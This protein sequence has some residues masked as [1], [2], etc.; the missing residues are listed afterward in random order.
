MMQKQ[1]SGHS[2]LYN[3]ANVHTGVLVQFIMRSF[4]HTNI[5]R[6]VGFS[7]KINEVIFSSY[8]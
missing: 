6:I 8:Q 2:H 1:V 5:P 3:K 4:T 7:I